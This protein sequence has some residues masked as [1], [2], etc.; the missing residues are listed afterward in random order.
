MTCQ[1]PLSMGFSRQ[2]YWS[3]LL[4]PPP[5]N[6]PDPGTEPVSPAL[7][8]DS[9]LTE[10][11]GRPSQLFLFSSVAQ[12]CL[13]LCNPMDC[14]T[15]GF[16]VHRHLPEITKTHVNWVGDTIQP[17]SSF[18]IS[19]SSCLQSFPASGSFPVSQFFTSGDQSIG[20]SALASVLP[21][22]IQAWFPL[23]HLIHYSSPS[24]VKLKGNCYS[25]SVDL[26]TEHPRG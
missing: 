5:G 14:G 19:F 24:D 13:T 11:S 7:Q 3:G 21:M 6:L 23:G 16:P 25:H 12:S 18:V 9:L 10:S 1:A 8:A 22:N 17:T 26:K 4:F 2:E 20:A 15:P